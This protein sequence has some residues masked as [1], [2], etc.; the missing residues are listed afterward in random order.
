MLAA[1]QTPLAGTPT[2]IILSPTTIPASPTPPPPKPTGT[3]APTTT[4]T[5]TQTPFATFHVV[6]WAE[7]VN[8]R[9]NPGYLFPV[10]RV[11]PEGSSLLVLGRAPGGEW[12]LVR[13]EEPVEGWVFG[14]LIESDQNLRNAPVIIPQNAQLLRGQVLDVKGT[15]IKG[16]GFSVVQG[17]GPK[18][19]TNTVLTDVYGEFFS[20]MP[21][22]AGGTWT[23]SYN[24]IAC[25]SNVWK[26]DECTYYKDEYS[27]KVEPEY[28]NILLPSSEWL[29]FTYK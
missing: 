25:D 7:N 23:V 20:F 10:L 26:D 18:A 15:P 29:L 9:S 22:N 13:T 1:C 24:A 5:P 12:F 3:S 8:L 21:L 4:L 19:P 16:V 17:S 2:A 11:L 6:T 27:G 14:M 28:A